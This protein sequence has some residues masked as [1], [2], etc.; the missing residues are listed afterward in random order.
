MEDFLALRELLLVRIVVAA[1]QECG[2]DVVFLAESAFDHFGSAVEEVLEVFGVNDCP[3]L[4]LSQ[5]LIV[6]YKAVRWLDVPFASARF[7]L[8][9]E[10]LVSSLCSL[11]RRPKASPCFVAMLP[12]YD[13]A[14]VFCSLSRQKISFRS[15]K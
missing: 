11:R 13:S 8:S 1:D 5:F 7:F 12:L 3:L 2:Q 15:S 14:A 9:G 6:F 4:F 10:S